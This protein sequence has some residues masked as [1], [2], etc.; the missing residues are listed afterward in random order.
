MVTSTIE[1]ASLLFD[2]RSLLHEAIDNGQMA[3]DAEHKWYRVDLRKD[4]VDEAI[5][6]LEKAATE[7]LDAAVPL[8]PLQPPIDVF[9]S[10][11]LTKKDEIELRGLCVIVQ[12]I[13]TALSLFDTTHI[14]NQMKTLL[15]AAQQLSGDTDWLIS[16][17]NQEE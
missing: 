2:I 16:G 12:C 9:S 14:S 15:E 3:E 8:L 10:E 5:L 6:L 7:G 13:V 1:V 17:D 4:R 11:V